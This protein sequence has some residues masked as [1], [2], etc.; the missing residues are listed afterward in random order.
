MPRYLSWLSPLVCVFALAFIALHTVRAD[1][2]P[3]S[4]P[5]V[6]NGAIAVTVIDSNSV[7]IEKARVA[8]YRLINV[9]NG[10]SPDAPPKPKR[11]ARGSTDD[12]G[13]YT[14][15]NIADGQYRVTA[16][17]KGQRNRASAT[18]SVTD[19]QSSPAITITLTTP[20]P[21]DTGATT[22]PSTMP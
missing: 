9:A 15:E 22:A 6:A 14:F 1:D 7:P 5:S 10:D 3:T 11:L 4:Q 21:T 18:V 2:T 17:M 16:S 19:D 12:S 8:L 20:P 13:K